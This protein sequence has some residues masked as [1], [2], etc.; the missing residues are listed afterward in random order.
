MDISLSKKGQNFIPK[1]MDDIHNISL[2]PKDIQ[3]ESKPSETSPRLFDSF[4]DGSKKKHQHFLGRE[5]LEIIKRLWYDLY[6]STNNKQY[7]RYKPLQFTTRPFFDNSQLAYFDG[8]EILEKQEFPV[9]V[10][11]LI[12]AFGEALEFIKSNYNDNEYKKIVRG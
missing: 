2:T 7:G 12:A 6:H 10:T 1:S 5:H 11:K 9:F 8:I 4:N 3:S